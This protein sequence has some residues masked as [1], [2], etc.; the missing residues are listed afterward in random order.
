MVNVTVPVGVVCDP[1]A[2]TIAVNVTDWP[3]VEGFERRRRESGRRQQAG[4]VDS[5][6]GCVRGARRERGIAAISRGDRVCAGRERGGR[7][8]GLVLAADDREGHGR[9]RL[10]VDGEGH[11]AGRRRLDV[12]AVTTA[13][14]VTDWP[15]V[16]G[17][18][19]DETVVTVASRAGAAVA[20][21]NCE[22]FPA[23]SVSVAV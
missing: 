23:A 21:E 1:V 14:N 10:A 17:F 20:S 16:E 15:T 22:V 9:L 19:V 2:A 3:T 8:L 5:L 7:E 4:R 13:V 11:R 12:G 6:R 18:S